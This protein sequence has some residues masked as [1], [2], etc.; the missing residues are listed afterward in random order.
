M[1]KLPTTYGND[2]EE[3][4]FAIVENVLT[5]K[6]VVALRAAIE[7]ASSKH[8]RAVSEQS[9]LCDLR[10]NEEVAPAYSCQ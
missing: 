8:P 9:R 3:R 2:I 1:L 7:Q 5:L 10:N 6:E 4:G